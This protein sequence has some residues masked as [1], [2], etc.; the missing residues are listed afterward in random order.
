MNAHIPGVAVRFDKLVI[1]SVAEA[2][3]ERNL[4]DVL[5]EKD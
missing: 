4:K 1:T 5:E 2:P 3:E